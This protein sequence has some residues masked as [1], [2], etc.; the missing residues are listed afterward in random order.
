MIVTD[1]EGEY[2]SRKLY[3]RRI[4]RVLFKLSL[5]PHD[6]SYKLIVEEWSN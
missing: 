4:R 5:C 1:V 2:G 3:Y 6:G